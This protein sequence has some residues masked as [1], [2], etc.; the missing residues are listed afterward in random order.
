MTAVIAGRLF[1]RGVKVQKQEYMA[2]LT[3]GAARVL[4]AR[5][6][7]DRLTDHTI[8]TRCIHEGTSRRHTMR[9]TTHCILFI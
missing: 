7:N 3:A 9:Q 4:Q 5:G 2:A 8:I 1:A 6:W